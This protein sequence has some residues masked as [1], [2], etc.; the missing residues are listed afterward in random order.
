MLAVAEQ[1]ASQIKAKNDPFFG[2]LRFEGRLAEALP[3]TQ[4]TADLAKA[5]APNKLEVKFYERDEATG[6]LR[7]IPADSPKVSTFVL[8]ETGLDEKALIEKMATA[9]PVPSPFPEAVYQIG[10]SVAKELTSAAVL[11]TLLSM[12]FMIVYIWFRFTGLRFGLAAVVALFHDIPVALGAL[13]IA[14]ALSGTAV[15]R[16]LLFNDLKINLPV[17]AAV[18][19]LM[20]YSINDT[21]VV[22][23]RIRE[24][25]RLKTKSD[26]EVIDGSINQT[27]SRT[28]LTGFTALLVI[29]FMYAFG[30]PGIHAFSFVMLI[31][32]ITGTYSSI[33]IASPIL[34]I[35][36]IFR[37]ESIAQR[38]VR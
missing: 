20:G 33:F 34:L 37:R 19:T 5:L 18:L 36:D 28:M 27:L 31:G 16:A 32:V 23:D 6:A 12:L 13:A 9:F 14:D 2:G 7:E 4:V 35:K 3:G 10:S 1:S 38:A 17:V 11:A 21:I 15:G 30:G 24:N 26:W 29:F 22:F 25:M 8:V